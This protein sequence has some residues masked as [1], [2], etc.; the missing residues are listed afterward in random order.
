[1]VK[2]VSQ[3][4]KELPSKDWWGRQEII[5]ALIARPGTEYVAYLEEGIRNHEDADVRNSAMEVYRA[6]G[7][8]ALPSL[9]SLIR[10]GDPEVR[11]F[12]VN[13]LCEIRDRSSLPLLAGA[14]RD[15]DVNVRCAAAEALGGC[16]E[17]AVGA[18]REALADEPWVAMAAVNS[19]GG[20]GGEAALSMLYECLDKRIYPEV[21][22]LA[23]EKAGGRD[24]IR[25]LTACFSEPGLRERALRA[26]IGI[27]EREGVRPSPEY[28]LSLVPM[29]VGMLG[30][31]DEETKKYAF[32]ALSWSDDMAAMSFLL[33]GVRDEELQEY[34][35][36]G[37]LGIGRR[38]V[39]GIID[40]MKGSCGGHRPILAKVLSMIG[41]PMALLQFAGDEDPEVRTEA[42]LAL[43]SLRMERAYRILNEMLGDDHEEVR[44]AA[45]RSLSRLGTDG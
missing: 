11:L 37:L 19:L 30:S 22:I 35:I 45:R 43:G 21:A 23:I 31:K 38:A 44:L 26:I 1:M 28:F 3:L 16:D 24:S 14:L 39:C 15:P 10:D 34:A 25:H 29:L 27:A 12:T 5:S 40:E 2:E 32:M 13:I 9:S 7:A 41:E 33:E 4:L 20:I 8:R 36:E 17:R 18:L 42:A 6:L